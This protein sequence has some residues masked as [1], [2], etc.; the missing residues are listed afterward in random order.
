MATNLYPQINRF[1]NVSEFKARLQRLE[2]ELPLDERILSAAEGSP[3]ARPLEVF[4]KTAGN[5][6]CIHPMEGWDGTAEGKPTAH[7]RH[8]WCGFGRSGAKLIYGCEAVAVRHDGRANPR[9]LLLRPEHAGDFA[10]LLES[11]RNTHIRC[12][13]DDRDLLVGL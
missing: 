6:W 13:G 12:F 11:L 3:L 4:G 10:E 2:I 9:Q 5:R 8:R 1:R 7:T